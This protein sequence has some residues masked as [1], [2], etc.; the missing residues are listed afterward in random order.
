VAVAAAAAVAVAVAVACLSAEENLDTA[1]LGCKLA[2]IPNANSAV[3]R[4]RQKVRAI[5]RE[6]H[7]RQRVGVPLEDA[8]RFRVAFRH[9][10]AV[11]RLDELFYTAGKDLHSEQVNSLWSCRLLVSRADGKGVQA[12]TVLVA[13]CYGCNY[14]PVR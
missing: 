5:R 13:E 1:L 2:N 3:H 4:I 7:A 11:K 10:T 6:F 9:L 8:N 12:Q 14:G